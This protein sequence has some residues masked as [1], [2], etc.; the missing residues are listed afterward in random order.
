MVRRLA[1]LVFIFGG[2]V[3]GQ[4]LSGSWS[5]KISLLPPPPA[6]DS[7]EFTLEG[8]L[9]EWA[10][11]GT[12]E[13][14]GTDGWVWQTFFTQGWIGP[15]SSEW[16]FLFGPLAPAFLYAHGKYGLLLSGIDLA[17]HTAM[18]G[19]NGPY[20]FTGG[21][22]GGAVVEVAQKLNDLEFSVELG[23]G[24][25]KQDFVILYSGAGT[26]K[27]I[28]PVDPFPGGLTFTYLKLGLEGVPLCCGVTLD[29]AFSFTKEGFESLT[30]T[31][32]SIPLCCGISFDTEVEF[33]T[34]TKRVSLK[35]KWAGIEG[36]FTVYGDAMFANNVWQG[37][38]VY[39]F[40]VRCDLGDCTYA[41]FLTAFNVA[42]VEE[43]LEEDVF[44][45]DEFEYVK[46]GFCGPGCCGS[47]WTLDVGLFFK[48]SGSL[49]GLSRVLLEA[50]IPVMA[51]LS[52]ELGLT[53]VVGG[54]AG[55]TVGWTFTF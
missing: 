12:A 13:F 36:C 41:E 20:T 54:Q 29:L 52:V 25:R 4:A 39:G 51:N 38:E 6:L 9:F 2:L 49:F 8:K 17:C 34:T 3:F 42:K 19:P 26:Y 50:A 11:G 28:L 43:I 15:V 40:K 53:G 55:L 32:K 23:L 21:P 31:A 10:V 47:K 46:L 45:N 5:A 14:F 30:A 27:K 33:T 24:A 37:I 22:S 16:M 18:V 7:M 44:Q 48:P 1:F 35:P